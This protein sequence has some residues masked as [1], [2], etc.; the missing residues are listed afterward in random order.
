MRAIYARINFACTCDL[1]LVAE[2]KASERVRRQ[3]NSW[4]RGD[5]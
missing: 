2:S 4:S 1:Q 3:I 5:Q